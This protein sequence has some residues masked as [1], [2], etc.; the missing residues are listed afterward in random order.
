MEIFNDIREAIPGGTISPVLIVIAIIFI[1]V[2]IKTVGMLLKLLLFTAGIAVALGV[3]PWAGNP[4]TG[5]VAACAA[6]AVND[7]AGGWQALAAQ[8]VTVEELSLDAVCAPTLEGLVAGSASVKLR[9]F[10]DIPIETWTVD[11]DGARPHAQ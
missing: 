7:A 6:D 1:V 5:E 3:A 8:R 2:A 10:F 4:V 11:G 9:T